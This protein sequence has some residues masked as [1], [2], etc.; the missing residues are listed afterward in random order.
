MLSRF[1][2]NERV[3]APTRRRVQRERWYRSLTGVACSGLERIFRA[4]ARAGSYSPQVARP[5]KL[6][7]LLNGPT[8]RPNP[9]AIP[10]G[11]ASLATPG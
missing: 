5:S 10:P 7:G 8:G 11:S 9:R 6:Q 1:R 2:G 4:M 3:D